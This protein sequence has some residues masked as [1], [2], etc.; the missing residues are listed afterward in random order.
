[1][2]QKPSD[3]VLTVN[4][5]EVL[6]LFKANKTAMIFTPFGGATEPENERMQYRKAARTVWK[7]L[8]KLGYKVDASPFK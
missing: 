4:G 6:V 2:L 3:Q 1:M 5:I 7:R 8:L